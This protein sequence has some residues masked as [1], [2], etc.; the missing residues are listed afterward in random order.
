M[1]ERRRDGVRVSV[2]GVPGWLGNIDLEA[3]TLVRRIQ[4]VVQPSIS[5]PA[6]TQKAVR[7]GLKHLHPLGDRRVRIAQFM[8]GEVSFELT[9]DGTTVTQSFVGDGRSMDHP[10]EMLLDIARGRFEGASED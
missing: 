3:G 4:G 6:K 9:L 5:L 1:S 7:A 10:M 8:E 2:S